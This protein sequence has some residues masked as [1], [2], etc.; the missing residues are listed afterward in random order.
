M[1]TE[2]ETETGTKTET[3]TVA[4]GSIL[5]TAIAITG[6]AWLGQQATPKPAEARAEA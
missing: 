4:A 2:T 5:H 1:A 3:K 6:S